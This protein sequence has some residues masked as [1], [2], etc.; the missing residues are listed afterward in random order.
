MI[1]FVVTI[2]IF[3]LIFIDQSSSFILPSTT[4]IRT[5]QPLVSSSFCFKTRSNS[6]VFT[7]S[8][9]Q[10]EQQEQQEQQPKDD[11][12]N[13][14]NDFMFARTPQQSRRNSLRFI[15]ST[16]VSSFVVATTSLSTDNI[17][18]ADVSDGTTL[19][20][21]AQQFSRIIRLK[22]DIGVRTY[23]V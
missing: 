22:T 14:M 1:P 4:T 10:Q 9:Q 7:S 17:A 2:C 13:L 18:Y 12:N 11:H 15:G 5:V 3:C 21:G 20:Q 16:I 8:C 6:Q 23:S 19:P